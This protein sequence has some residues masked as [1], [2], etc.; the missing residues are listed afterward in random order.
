M[1]VSVF[2][3]NHGSSSG[4]KQA[5][6]NSSIHFLNVF[7]M[8]KLS[9]PTFRC[10]VRSK[11]LSD[12]QYPVRLLVNWKGQSELSLG[13]SLPS[14]SL[15]DSSRQLVKKSCPNSKMLNQVIQSKKSELEKA[16]LV[17]D[18]TGQTYSHRELVS[19]VKKP[20]TVEEIDRSTF[21]S[22]FNDFM[23]D[24]RLGAS[25]QY[26]TVLKH[27]LSV[28][29]DVRMDSVDGRLFLRYAESKGWSASY[30][31]MV[32]A[33]WKA[34]HEHGIEEGILSK[35]FTIKKKMVGKV[36]RPVERYCF[37][38]ERQLDFLINQY[39]L[40]VC[41][42]NGAEIA[43]KRHVVKHLSMKP[44]FI[45]SF[46]EITKRGSKTWAMG[47]YLAM[48]LMSGLSPIDMAKMRVDD[49]GEEVD[50]ES[51]KL[52]WTY[53]GSRTKTGVG[54]QWPVVQTSLA[55]AI[56]LPFIKTAHKR[57]GLLFNILRSE[58]ET[59]VVDM[60][61]EKSVRSKMVTFFNLINPKLKELWKELNSKLADKTMKFDEGLT[62]YS[63]RHSFASKYV[64]HSDNLGVLATVMGR[65]I[66]TLS[67]YVHRIK[68]SQTL[69]TEIGKLGM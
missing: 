59:K 13:I 45:M 24:K 68:E 22:L 69:M 35:P 65:S 34:V 27:L 56:L 61:D 38:S 21:S 52:C 8:P 16:R 30:R 1:K 6:K 67:V 11:P 37:L 40:T 44:E 31:K 62:M 55:K 17:L 20:Q 53:T 12:G 64:N 5:L 58:F 4:S 10:I 46:D 19:S 49:L 47:L 25:R 15:F 23:L 32:F 51:G 48:V 18:A 54:F 60:N 43:V 42:A 29:G 28:Y 63:G 66:S 39:L 7:D 57:D 26:D 50:A 2:S 9:Q 41:G 3:I 14:P 33:L 36:Q